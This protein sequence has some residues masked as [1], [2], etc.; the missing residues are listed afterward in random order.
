MEALEPFIEEV[1]GNL[2][3]I[4]NL[5]GNL[6]DTMGDMDKDMNCIKEEMD[7]CDCNPNPQPPGEYICGGTGGWRRVVHLD[8]TDPNAVCPSGWQNNGHSTRTCGRVSTGGLKCDS[9]SFPVPGGCYTKVCG[10]ITAYQYVYPDGFQSYIEEKANTIDDAYVSGVS[11]TH[12]SP[13]QHIWTF[14]CGVSQVHPTRQDVCPCD[15]DTN[16][17]VPPFVGADYFL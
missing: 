14:A 1:R 5:L 13:R 17:S 7:I 15:S 3:Q 8:M 2:S 4:N 16:I 6:N 10:R 11:L 12:G 9:V